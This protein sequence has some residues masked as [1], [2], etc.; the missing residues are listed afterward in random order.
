MIHILSRNSSLALLSVCS[1]LSMCGCKSGKN[2][3]PSSIQ[4]LSIIEVSCTTTSQ[5]DDDE[6]T[7]ASII[8]LTL[9]NTA[10]YTM[11]LTSNEVIYSDNEF[12]TYNLQCSSDGSVWNLSASPITITIPAND[13]A[14]ATLTSKNFSNA[15]ASSSSV[16]LCTI[17]PYPAPGAGN[18]VAFSS[19]LVSCSP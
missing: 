4:T 14:V 10:D 6:A 13:T 3:S 17:S 11:Y 9:S 18:Y 2:G 5:G 15:L 19:Q 12:I 8:T 16:L 1:I 7:P